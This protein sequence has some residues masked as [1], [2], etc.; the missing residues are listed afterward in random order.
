MQLLVWSQL[1]AEERLDALAR[2]R[3]R[4]DAKL[5]A[6]VHKIVDDVRRKSWRA[7]CDHALKLDGRMPE[8]IDVAPLADKA[9][10]QMAPDDLEA[11][12]LAHDNIVKFHEAARPKDTSV[13]VMPG[14]IVGKSWRAIERVGL[15]V[16]G[17]DP[18]LFSSLLMLAVPARIAGVT[19]MLVMTPPRSDGLIDP[20]LALAAETCGIDAI[21]TL[22]GAQAI[23]AM[24]FGAG[25]I[26][27]VMK[28]AGPGNAYVSEA[29]TYLSALG[30]GPAIDLP[31]G[32]SEL[33]VIADESADPAIV[34]A[35]LLS[36]AE[37]DSNAQVLLVSNS[38]ALAASVESELSGQLALLPRAGIARGAL[39]HARV[40]LAPSLARA[41]EIANLYAPEHLSLNVREPQPLLTSI[42]NAGAIFA[43]RHAAESFG[44][45]LAGSSHVLP[46]DGAARAWSGVGVETFMKAI[47]I[48]RVDAEAAARLAGPA[49]ALARLEG[50]EAH[51]R[52]AEARLAGSKRAAA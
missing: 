48:Q 13:E 44:D 19:E 42:R 7:L 49:A 31:A 1:T 14:L 46:T 11:L 15:Y 20:L 33:M 30:A 18:S 17:G 52:A 29:K 9:R 16:P 39:K 28:I 43:G 50:L 47:S 10:R 2:P 23:A 45:Y 37:H 8:R 41:V 27:P 35:D 22:G 40:L 25:D 38:P 12:S 3:R 32:P 6:T 51:A 4:S 34:A 36:Q 21:W 26:R 24:A 5:R